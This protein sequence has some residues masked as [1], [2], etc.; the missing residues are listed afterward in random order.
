MTR[1]ITYPHRCGTT[2]TLTRECY[3]NGRSLV[4]SAYSGWCPT[5]LK[6]VTIDGARGDRM[7]AVDNVPATR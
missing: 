6:S 2:L 1:T 3:T 5:C 7:P 4:G